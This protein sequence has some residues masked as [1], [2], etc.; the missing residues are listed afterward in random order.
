[1]NNAKTLA[2][3][4][5][6]A[7]EEI[8]AQDVILMDVRGISSIT[9]YIIVCSSNS[10]AHQKAIARDI[11]KNVFEQ[12]SVWPTSSDI[13]HESM[14]SVLDYIDVMVH[15]MSAD[16]RENYNLE[17]LWSDNSRRS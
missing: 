12:L 7:A 2:D 10:P 16:M 17:K 15:I 14:W 5:V 8:S 1:M 11:E 4:C 9:D 6:K 13:N 3:A